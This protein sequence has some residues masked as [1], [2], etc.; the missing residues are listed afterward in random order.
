M[1]N[2][3]QVCIAAHLLLGLVQG[4]PEAIITLVWYLVRCWYPRNKFSCSSSGSAPSG[5]D[6][7]T[8][9]LGRVQLHCKLSL[10]WK[11][12]LAYGTSCQHT[13]A[14]QF[15][16]CV[17]LR[18]TDLLPQYFSNRSTEQLRS[19]L[20]RLWVTWTW[21]QSFLETFQQASS[22]CGYV[23]MLLLHSIILNLKPIL[24]HAVIVIPLLLV[25]SDT[26][27]CMPACI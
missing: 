11:C 4:K 23:D 1:A 8:E 6:S 27:F 19:I 2:S 7:G 16:N 3:A 5:C 12:Y 14:K 25:Y 13:Y 24:T 18:S 20:C 22:S 21:M 26:P 17:H 10:Y 9:W 15:Y